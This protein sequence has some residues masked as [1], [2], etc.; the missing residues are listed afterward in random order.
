M[1]H[2]FGPGR[3]GETKG[4]GNCLHFSFCTHPSACLLQ[5]SWPEPCSV[6]TS[7]PV[8]GCAAQGGCGSKTC[9]PLPSALL[10][11]VQVAKCCAACVLVEG[12]LGKSM[13]LPLSLHLSGGLK[14]LDLFL[15]VIKIELMGVE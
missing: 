4:K 15:T 11:C 9:F 12:T 14:A 6:P 5:P 10:G 1:R 7:C 13:F 8:R 3:A 2:L